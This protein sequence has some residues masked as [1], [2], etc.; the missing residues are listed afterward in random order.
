M[1][2]MPIKGYTLI[3]FLFLSVAAMHAYPRASSTLPANQIE[4]DSKTEQEGRSQ[5]VT[6]RFPVE[7]DPNTARVYLN[8]RDVTSRF[9]DSQCNIGFCQSAL[10]VEADGLRMTKNVLAATASK[11]DGQG[12]ASG[13]L[14]F[15]ARSTLNLRMQTLQREADPLSSR[16][17][18]NATVGTLT[19][20]LPPTIS[21]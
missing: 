13:R 2:L 5:R 9:T 11:R 8:G 20:F 10:L 7:A 21:F 17:Q 12:V 19:G 15:A 14:R 6:L 3:A 4:I 18:A 1:R 16:V